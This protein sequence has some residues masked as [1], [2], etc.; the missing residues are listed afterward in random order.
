MERIFL[1]HPKSSQCTRLGNCR[2]FFSRNAYVYTIY[3]SFFNISS[4]LWLVLKLLLQLKIAFVFC[5]WFG[6][7]SVG[8]LCAKY[9]ESPSF[10]IFRYNRND[11][12]FICRILLHNAISIRKIWIWQFQKYKISVHFK[13]FRTLACN[14]RIMNNYE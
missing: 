6:C 2:K 10:I 1:S 3:I 11:L 9:M 12:I 13:N 5:Y 14:L 8:V 4:F 7:E